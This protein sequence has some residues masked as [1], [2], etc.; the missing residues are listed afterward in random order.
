MKGCDDVAYDICIVYSLPGA[1]VSAADWSEASSS[2]HATTGHATQHGR[3]ITP[4]TNTCPDLEQT[5]IHTYI[6]NKYY[7]FHPDLMILLSLLNPVR[8]I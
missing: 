4:H 6:Y 1:I 8:I 3:R 2:A 5:D 7:Y